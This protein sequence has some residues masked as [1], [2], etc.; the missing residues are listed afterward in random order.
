LVDIT[1]GVLGLQGAFEKHKAV[2]NRLNIASKDVRYPEDLERCDGLIIPGG[3]STTISELI[4]FINI[5]TPL[6][7]FA[8]TQPVMGTCAG[9]IM[10]ANKI[11]DQRVQTL[12]LIDIEITRNAFGRQV[13]SFISDVRVLI[14]GN[15]VLIKG[16]FIRA[17]RIKSIGENV[18]VLGSLNG[19]SVFIQQNRHLATSFH[20]ELSNSTVIHEYF[21][22]LIK[23]P[24]LAQKV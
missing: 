21:V 5:R 20:P 6:L 11:Y 16:V 12:N 24:I 17:P 3:E 13:D 9:M 14:N 1:V 8:E 15:E 4:N 18:K 23:E 22:S 19:E 2:L 10:M 7:N